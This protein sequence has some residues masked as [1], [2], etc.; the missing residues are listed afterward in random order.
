MSHD[1]ATSV[2]SASGFNPGKPVHGAPKPSKQT[3]A[4]SP[5]RDILKRTVRV[6]ETAASALRLI[7]VTEE[8]ENST[9]QQGTLQRS[10]LAGCLAEQLADTAEELSSTIH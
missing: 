6:I 5:D 9:N 2:Q 7:Q 8:T 4:P 3:A 10:K 1:A